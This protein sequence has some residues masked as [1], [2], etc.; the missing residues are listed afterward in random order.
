MAV[1]GKTGSYNGLPVRRHPNPTQTRRTPAVAASH[2]NPDNPQK[3]VGAASLKHT[4]PAFSVSGVA[5]C[6]EPPRWRLVF[7]VGLSDRSTTERAGHAPNTVHPAAPM[8]AR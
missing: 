8:A 4:R 1:A 6:F 3:P 2:Q 5:H 7:P